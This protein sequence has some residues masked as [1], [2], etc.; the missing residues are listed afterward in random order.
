MRSTTSL[1][2][3]HFD[4]AALVTLFK[5]RRSL[6]CA[7]RNLPLKFRGDVLSGRLAD[8]NK[9]GLRH[10]P[11]NKRAVIL[12]AGGEQ[13][14]VKANAFAVGGG[15]QQNIN[16][17]I[18]GVGPGGAIVEG[19]VGIGVAENEGRN[20]ARFKLLAQAACQR[21]RDILFRER[22]A[23]G[24][25]AIVTPMARI[26]DRVKMECG[27]RCLRGCVY[28]RWYSWLSRSCS[29]VARR[30]RHRNGRRDGAVSEAGISGTYITG[31]PMLFFPHGRRWDCLSP[32]VS[33][34]VPE[35]PA[36]RAWLM[37]RRPGSVAIVGFTGP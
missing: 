7:N 35:Q 16:C 12:A 36:A 31:L 9:A 37:R 4:I 25:A 5:G 14:G 10:L 13:R 15:V 6:Q 18:G 22:V 23:E 21:E 19:H 29:G 1:S 8:G 3:R 2:G 27:W 24:C 17:G 30:G 34:A 26:D 20:A 28:C 11:G 33:V 32:K